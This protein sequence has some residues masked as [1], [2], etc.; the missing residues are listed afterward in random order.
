MTIA[1]II[2]LDDY[3]F[4]NISYDYIMSF[5]YMTMSAIILYM[6]ICYVILLHDYVFYIIV[7]DYMLCHFVR[8]LYVFYIIIYDYVLCY[9]AR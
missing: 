8:W 2:L 4:S 1:Y 6:T 5:C 9:F 3:V 7:Y